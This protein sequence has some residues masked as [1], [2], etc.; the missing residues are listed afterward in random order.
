[1]R[2]SISSSDEGACAGRVGWTVAPGDKILQIVND[3]DAQDH[4]LVGPRDRAHQNV[5]VH[6]R[7]S[8]PSKPYPPQRSKRGA[9]PRRAA[10]GSALCGIVTSSK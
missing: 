3:Y 1:M 8:D 9:G 10:I 2:A 6:S 5:D 4:A 7:A